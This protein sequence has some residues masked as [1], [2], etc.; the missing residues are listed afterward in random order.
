MVK[1]LRCAMLLKKT[2]FVLNLTDTDYINRIKGWNRILCLTSIRKIC[3]HSP[4]FIPGCLASS[5][6][7]TSLPLTHILKL[8]TDIITVVQSSSYVPRLSQS[9]YIKSQYSSV[10]LPFRFWFMQLTS[11]P[12]Q[13]EPPASSSPA[14]KPWS[15]LSPWWW[16]SDSNWLIDFPV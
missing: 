14:S 4:A 16:L 5:R 15:H 10:S 8:N 3:N 2:I 13:S 12:P 6:F 7:F 9:A 1:G 11:S